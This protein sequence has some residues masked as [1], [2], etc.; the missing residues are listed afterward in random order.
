MRQMDGVQ[1]ENACKAQKIAMVLI[2]FHPLPATNRKA[3]PA[4][5]LIAAHVTPV[6]KKMS[7][8]QRVTTNATHH[9]KHCSISGIIIT[10]SSIN[11]FNRMSSIKR[12]HRHHFP[13]TIPTKFWELPSVLWCA[14][15]ETASWKSS[16]PSPIPP[17]RQTT[18]EMDKLGIWG[19]STSLHLNDGT[20]QGVLVVFC[21]FFG[22]VCLD[23]K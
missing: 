7:H 17:K 10:A 21:F 18:E 3:S 14:S 15:V 2:C 8:H 1:L 9:L 5:L 4:H 6:A 12:I 20:F 23:G 22:G 11:H 13:S 19:F 16:T